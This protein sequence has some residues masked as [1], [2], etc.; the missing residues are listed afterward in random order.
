MVLKNHP[1]TSNVENKM[2][3]K[4]WNQKIAKTLLTEKNS[5][6]NNNDFALIEQLTNLLIESDNENPYL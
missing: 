6:N 4:V 2:N 1:L 5:E 3:L